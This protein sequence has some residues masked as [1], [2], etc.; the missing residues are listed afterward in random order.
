MK[1]Y[2]LSKKWFRLYFY[3]QLLKYIKDINESDNIPAYL[4][5]F[6]YYNKWLGRMFCW[7]EFKEIQNN[8]NSNLVDRVRCIG[9]I[10]FDNNENRRLFIEE[11][12]KLLKNEKK[13]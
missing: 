10:E 13:I 6:K 7:T 11:C 2:L 5:N 3:N 1:K 4:C 9:Y 8:K 12:I